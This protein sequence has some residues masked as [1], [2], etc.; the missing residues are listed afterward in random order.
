MKNLNICIDIDGTITD[1][2]FWLDIANKYFNKNV[3]IDKVTE[4]KVDIVMGV[5]RDDYYDFYDKNKFKMH[6]DN[7]SLR[8]NAKEVIE[9]LIKLNNIYFVTARDKDLKLLTYSYLNNN[10]IP[11]D[12]IFVLGTHYKVDMARKLKCDIF[13]EDS[14]ENAL[15]LSENGFK[16]LL[17]DTNYNR[18]PLNKNIVRVLNW[19]EIYELIKETLLCSKAI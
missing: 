1:P 7:V 5:T 4:Y 11:Y 15:Q 12:D 3:T 8:E 16:V 17:I 6:N 2:Y 14:Y 9:E 13:I 18:K 19:N 10:G